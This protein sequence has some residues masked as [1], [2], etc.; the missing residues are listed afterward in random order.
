MLRNYRT[1]ITALVGIAIALA[2]WATISHLQA[3]SDSYEQY[4]AEASK[5][6]ARDAEEQIR[7]RCSRLPPTN[8]AECVRKA[9]Q[10]AR[11][12][13]RSEKD[14]AA[15]KVTAWWTKIM[16]EA[17]LT[18]LAL[19]I[20]GVVLIWTTFH[21]TRKANEIAQDTAKRQLRAYMGID[22]TVLTVPED[23]FGKGEVVFRFKNFGATP[24]IQLKTVIS[25]GVEK[26]FQGMKTEKSDWQAQG[27]KIAVD[28]P[29]GGTLSRRFNLPNAVV[30]ETNEISASRQA[31]Y[32]QLE[33][34]YFDIYGIKYAQELLMGCHG[35]Y[36]R[37]GL[38]TMIQHTTERT[39]PNDQSQASEQ[40]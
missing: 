1:I 5:H 12:N 18:G 24:A 22:E 26:Y 39:A 4:A 34:E 7:G 27:T 2:G 32:V 29:P 20:I 14:L 6:Y 38:L 8:R 16:G 11:E 17:A 37:E 36:Y 30:S 25:I 19:S 28:V 9:D 40:A 13:Q 21:E 31:L 10:A 15:Q 33:I 23:E 3:V 35:R